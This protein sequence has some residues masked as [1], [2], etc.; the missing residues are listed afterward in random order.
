M[1]MGSRSDLAIARKAA[2]TLKSLGVD[3]EVTV[4][5]AHR[6]PADAAAY[7]R[8]AESRGIKVIIAVAGLSAALPG[9]IAAHTQLPVIGVPVNAGTVGG[10]DALLSVAQMPPGVPVAAMGIDS[11]KNAALF[12]ARIIA[13][14]NR[15]L[16]LKMLD[17]T[18]KAGESFMASRSDL[19]GLPPA[20]ESAFI[21]LEEK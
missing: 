18:S 3:Y 8:N 15:E 17:E 20:P 11:A 4:A 7:A 13:L 1:I 19:E 21:K 5:S 10:I 14:S 6:T 16:Q 9:F 2:E 12:A